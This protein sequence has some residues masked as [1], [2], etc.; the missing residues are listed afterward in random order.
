MAGELPDRI[1]VVCAPDAGLRGEGVE[2]GQRV[3]LGVDGNV[4]GE[5]PCHVRGHATAGGEHQ[6][7]VDLTDG[8]NFHA[9]PVLAGVE[10]VDD[11]AHGVGLEAVPFLP[12]PEDDAPVVASSGPAGGQT[13]KSHC[14]QK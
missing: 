6:L 7:A 11:R 13:A 5:Q 1:K 2:R 10:I 9:H 4:L 14:Q 3:V 8:G 12:V